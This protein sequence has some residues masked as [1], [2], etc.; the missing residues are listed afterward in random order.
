DLREIGDAVATGDY[1]SHQALLAGWRREWERSGGPTRKEPAPTPAREFSSPLRVSHQSE[2][3]HNYARVF[4]TFGVR[5]NVDGS[6]RGVA[7]RCPWCGED[8]FFLN[9]RTGFHRCEHCLESGDVT[10]FLT[11]LHKQRLEAT[12][13][14]HYTRLQ[15]KRGISWRTLKLH[16]LAFDEAEDR[17]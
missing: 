6:G 17:W 12:T 2:L 10:T 7:D 8:R 14:A 9:I 4:E 15:E 11:R 1:A 16:E 5:I 13:S 3:T